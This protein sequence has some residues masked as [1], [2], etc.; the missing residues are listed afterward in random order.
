MESGNELGD[1]LRARRA[2]IT[3]RD[4]GLRD[5]GERRVPGLRR[6]EVAL[7]AGVSTDYYIRLE[8]G[9]E[10]HPSEQVLR[11]IAG[12]LGLDGAEIDELTAAA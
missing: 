6:D 10:R 8:Q 5:D 1:Y 4:V 9:R 12:A 2:S 3:P 7:L 11:A